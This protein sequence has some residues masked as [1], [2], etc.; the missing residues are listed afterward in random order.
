VNVSNIKPWGNYIAVV[1][2]PAVDNDGTHNGVILPEGFGLDVMDKAIVVGIGACVEDH[3]HKPEGF[4]VGSAVWFPHGQATL[5]IND[6]TFVQSGHIV[7]WEPSPVPS[8]A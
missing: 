4:A 5:K 7:C 2:P 8:E 6:L 3:G 1:D